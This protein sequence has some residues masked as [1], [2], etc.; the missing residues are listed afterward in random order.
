MPDASLPSHD[1]TQPDLRRLESDLQHLRATVTEA[2]GAVDKRVGAAEA[3]IKHLR[4]TTDRTESE[5][6]ALRDEVREFKAGF[7]EAL[8]LALRSELP[9]ALTASLVA[10]FSDEEQEEPV[11][12]LRARLR[13]E[14]RDAIRTQAT[15][16][17]G[18]VLWVSPLLQIIITAFAVYALVWGT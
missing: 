7:P 3:D 4:T 2:L 1:D 9:V 16:A 11:A 18:A 13:R 10:I 12:T 17:R 14:N 5:V 6:Q 15:Q 8:A